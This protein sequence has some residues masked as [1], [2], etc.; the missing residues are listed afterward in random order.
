MEKKYSIVKI[1]YV[2][3]RLLMILLI[4][5]LLTFL[6]FGIYDFTK[7]SLQSKNNDVE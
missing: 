4:A 1:G 2:A 7:D 5:A 6:A 3:A